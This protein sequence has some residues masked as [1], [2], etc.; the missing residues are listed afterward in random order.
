MA[1]SLIG[2]RL[3]L[4]FQRGVWS[5]IEGILAS[6]TPLHPVH[7]ATAVDLQ[8]SLPK[9]SAKVSLINPGSDIQ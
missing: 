9:L 1:C 3:A 5:A 4:L 2:G 7:P 6:L 8:D